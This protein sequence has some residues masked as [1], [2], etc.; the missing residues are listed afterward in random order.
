MYRLGHYGAALLA[1]APLGAVVAL[2]GP[3]PAAIVGGAVVLW[4]STA[5]DLDHRIPL[6]EHR[7]PTHT[8][9]F[10]LLV[11]AATAAGAG[12]LAGSAAPAMGVALVVF[13]FVVGTLSI[14]S[15]LAADVL[16][17]SGIRPLWPVSSRR[18]S[19]NVVRAS[20]TLANYALFCLGVAATV[21][22][23]VVVSA[24]A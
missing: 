21:V 15:H 11:G 17:P 23:V 8:L 3:H 16:T 9:L 22:A 13:G 12:L 18:Y 1:Y 7:G 6:V 4:L 20:N 5:P 19:L 24:V 10:A 14:L 2:V